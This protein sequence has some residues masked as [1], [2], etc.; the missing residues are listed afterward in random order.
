MKPRRNR[1][2]ICG[3]TPRRACTGIVSRM[4]GQRITG[5]CWW[6][7]EM[8]TLCS[9]CVDELLRRVDVVMRATERHVYGALAGIYAVLARGNKRARA[10]QALTVERRARGL[11]G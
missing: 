10:V 11:P 3:C 2:R 7:D 1:C 5:T 6:V 8:G 9:A 4:G